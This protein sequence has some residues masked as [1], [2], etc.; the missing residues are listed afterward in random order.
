[1]GGV[2]IKQMISKCV[3][4]MVKTGGNLK[5]LDGFMKSFARFK[6]EVPEGCVV[7]AEFRGVSISASDQA[8][9]YFHALRDLYANGM[10]YDKEYAKSELC[11]LYG[12]ALEADGV[13]E[14]P[15][16]SGHVV[17]IWDQVYF[18]KSVAEYTRR[19]MYALIE[20][21][22]VACRENSIDTREVS[23]MYEGWDK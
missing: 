22:R 5:V 21:V 17:T 8:F 16:W 10:G 4:H 15:Q 3:V 14:I 20:G 12:V 2:Q 18:R 1:M 23:D 7:E 11:C 9:K 13:K 6:S 19:E